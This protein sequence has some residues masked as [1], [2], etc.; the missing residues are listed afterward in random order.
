MRVPGGLGRGRRGLAGRSRR[1]GPGSARAAAGPGWPGGPGPAGRSRPG[2]PGYRRGRR[3]HVAVVRRVTAGPLPFAPPARCRCRPR[4]CATASP[5]PPG[6]GGGH[7]RLGRGR[8]GPPARLLGGRQRRHRP[9]RGGLARAGHGRHGRHPGASSSGCP[10][11][12]CCPAART[13]CVA[14]SR[15]PARA[16]AGQGGHARPRRPDAASSA[17]ASS[18]GSASIRQAVLGRSARRAG[19]RRQAAPV[20]PD[21]GT[22]LVGILAR[23]PASAG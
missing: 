4:P 10:R 16:P 11:A 7:D 15:G 20:G 1:S 22:L 17:A 3:R 12:A 5:S 14:V 13:R 19:R 23:P 21:G 8:L 18:R 9:G 6:R 2:R